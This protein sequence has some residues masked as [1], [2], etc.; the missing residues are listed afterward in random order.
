MPNHNVQGCYA[1]VRDEKI[2]YIGSGFGRGSA[3]R[4]GFGLSR[5]LAGGYL[6]RDRSREGP[7]GEKVYQFR[8]GY[9]GAYTIG[10]PKYG[11]LEI[12]LEHYQI[13]QFAAELPDNKIKIFKSPEA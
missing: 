11:Y 2:T 3:L 6:K 4:P 13:G 7:R 8:K 9:T 10:L 1:L 12:S 5:R